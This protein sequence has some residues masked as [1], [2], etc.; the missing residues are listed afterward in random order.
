MLVC[1]TFRK[2]REAPKCF[3]EVSKTNIINIPPVVMG[4]KVR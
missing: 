2:L 3:G 4:L 1:K